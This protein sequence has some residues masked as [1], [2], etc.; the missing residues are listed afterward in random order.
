MPLSISTEKSAPPQDFFEEKRDL[1]SFSLQE[2][3]I[4]DVQECR[5]LCTITM[6]D[7]C[8]DKVSVVIDQDAR[9][10]DV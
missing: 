1:Y 7:R 9:H 5:R 3:Y 4:R 2:M 6:S 8:I 10:M